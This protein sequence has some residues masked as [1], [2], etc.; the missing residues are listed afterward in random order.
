MK[1]EIF[2]LVLLTVSLMNINAQ[3]A[4]VALVGQ[5][6]GGWPGMAGNPGPIDVHQMTSTDGENWTLDAITLTNSTTTGDGGVKFRANNNWSINWGSPSFP[7]GIGTQDG[8]NILVQ[9]GTYNVTF[10]INTGAYS[11]IQVTSSFNLIGFNG[12]FNNFGATVPMV[13]T[14]GTSYFK[15]DYQFSANG[16]KF[17]RDTP[18]VS[19]WGAT[20]FPSGT[21][22]LNG[23]TIPLTSGFYNVYFNKNSLA[24]NFV[25]VPVS[26]IGDAAIDFSTDID[27]TTTD[28]INFMLMN[29]A[30]IGGK[31]LKFRTNYSWATN[32]GG[33]TFPVGIGVLS[34]AS[35]DILVDVSGNYNI[36]FNR[37]TGAYSFVAVAV[38]NN[39]SQYATINKTNGESISQFADLNGDG[40]IDFV[41]TD[42]NRLARFYINTGAGY[43]NG[44]NLQLPAYASPVAMKDFDNDGKIDLLSNSYYDQTCL[45]NLIRIYW[46]SGT[47]GSLFS[48]TTFTELPLP[49]RNY[50]M[51]SKEIDFNSDGKL[52][53]IATSMSGQSRT[54][55]N[56]G[57]RN[58]TVQAN[59]QWPRDLYYTHTKDFNGDGNAD[60]LSIGKSGWADSL[61]G[62]YYYRGNGD[63]TFQT[64]I[65][66]FATQRTYSGTSI[67]LEPLNNNIEDYGVY[68]G[69]AISQNFQ[70]AKW[71]G[72]NNFN[73]STI[74]IPANYTVIQSSDYDADGY[75]DLILLSQT[76]T[77][78]LKYMKNNGGG[79]FN[80]NLSDIV[81]NSSFTL[82]GIANEKDAD[83]SLY[84][85]GSNT[86]QLIIYIKS[87]DLSTPTI[88]AITPTTSAA[89]ATVTIT[90]TNFTG[91]TAVS[92]GGTAASSFTVVNA[93]TI[94][95]IVGSGAS[96]SVSVTTPN[97]TASLLGYTFCN[98]I[99]PTFTPVGSI[100]SGTNIA[101]LPTTSNNGISGTWSPALNNTTTTTYTFTPTAGQCSNTITQTITITAPKVT[102]A[103]S[104]VAPVAALPD[105]I[106]I[107]DTTM[108]NVYYHQTSYLNPTKLVFS[109]LTNVSGY[110]YFHQTNNI[111]EVEFPLLTNT[112]GFVYFHQNLS[113]KK[114]KAPN[115][116]TIVNYLYVN[117][118]SNLEELNICN[119]TNINC[120]NQEPYIYVTNNN[121]VQPC[122]TA[123]LNGSKLTTN[124]ITQFSRNTAVGGGTFTNTCGN[125]TGNICWS[126]S[127]NPTSN[128]FVSNSSGLGIN[129]TLNLTGL[130]PNTTYYVRAFSGSVYGNQI[131]FTTLP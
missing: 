93:T 89:G 96:G 91:A 34:N 94:T 21:A 37:V 107:T 63:G 61:Y 118:N 59:F 71:N 12:G 51:Q 31:H 36:F 48:T 123:I 45:N 99:N 74:A 114:I 7:N 116:Q 126:T 81:Q 10:N 29:Q 75:Q 54:Y 40:K 35:S 87:F 90:G 42:T 26:I 67:N 44:G 38:N 117:G 23:P 20:A 55:K 24:Y 65:I 52:D 22:S 103:I 80:S 128:D 33:T 53:V 108:N 111:V 92:F 105:I 106:Y 86:T 39:L 85:H 102:S 112:G 18:V 1:K 32:W 76:G 84:I 50:C 95:A 17:V 9:A 83:N 120:S 16:V 124:P 79:L 78:T 104:F 15:I 70:L 130:T 62:N 98:P 97:G 64:P 47:T 11:F 13:T 6:A 69:T 4:S 60:F 119:L 110:I 101:P 25:P 27:M 14:D 115:L 57:S 28:G 113:M 41:T 5:A 77:S 88:T 2:L 122:F 73:F 121:G 131:S 125:P 8:A 49:S 46:N 68:V 56:N 100:C 30:L 82:N 66:N 19:V 43:S 129:F 58:F 3:I 72:T 109:N 127:P